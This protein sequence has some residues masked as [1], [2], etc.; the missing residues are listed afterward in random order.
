LQIVSRY[1][2]VVPESTD[3]G[4]GTLNPGDSAD[5]AGLDRREES[6]VLLAV[7]D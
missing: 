1:S 2:P 6:F 7:D 3:P 5:A 4:P